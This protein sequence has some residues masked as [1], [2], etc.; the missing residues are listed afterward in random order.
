MLIKLLPNTKVVHNAIS[1]QDNNN[2]ADGDGLSNE[3]TLVAL[4]SSAVQ[5][6]F[7]A[8]NSAPFAG[9]IPCLI[10]KTQTPKVCPDFI[11]SSNM[12]SLFHSFIY[13]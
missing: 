10:K 7:Q 2:R 5:S 8:A 9:N 6:S 11:I 13:Y 12:T 4:A 1:Q 3:T